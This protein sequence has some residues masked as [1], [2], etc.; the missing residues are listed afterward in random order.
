MPAGLIHTEDSV[1]GSGPEAIGFV[2]LDFQA[3]VSEA[4]MGMRKCR[5]FYEARCMVAGG[6]ICHE[7]TVIG[8]NPNV[9]L[10]VAE[11][12]IDFGNLPLGPSEGFGVDSDQVAGRGAHPDVAV[13]AL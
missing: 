6:C 8:G 9:I 1:V 4:L 5:V 13:G 7:Q 3:Q 10:V 2:R 11:D 12:A